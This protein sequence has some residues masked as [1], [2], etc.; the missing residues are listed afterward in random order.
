MPTGSDALVNVAKNTPRQLAKKSGFGR[1]AADERS[2]VGLAR[3]AGIVKR[4][5]TFQLF[6]DANTPARNIPRV[7]MQVNP[8]TLAF[9][10]KK[11]VGVGY[12]Y[13]NFTIQHWHDRHT[14]ITGSGLIK[15]FDSDNREASESFRR[16][17]ELINIFKNCGQIL[18]DPETK[19][20]Y[21]GI[22]GGRSSADGLTIRR[23]DWSK[24]K[25]SPVVVNNTT[26]Y[27]FVEMGYSH[28]RY[29]GVFETFDVLEEQNLPQSFKY[30]FT[31]LVFEEYDVTFGILD[32]A[33]DAKDLFQKVRK[34]G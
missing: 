9:R 6:E 15:S 33:L 3:K 2:I 5:I 28:I 20:T 17:N 29:R 27:P 4:K 14:V 7:G 32:A 24:G 16:F 21:K 22:P 34:F 18:Q 1:L 26:S 19:S 31:F 13:G 30:N 12:T 25:L 23:E 10:A 11:Q 8:N